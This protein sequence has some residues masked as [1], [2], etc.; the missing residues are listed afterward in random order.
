MQQISAAEIAGSRAGAEVG[1]AAAAVIEEGVKEEVEVEVEVEII[2][3]VEGKAMNA[4][5]LQEACVFVLL[6]VSGSCCQYIQEL[7][8]DPQKLLATFP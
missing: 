6:H 5:M 4:S 2:V 1:A 7:P 8:P 3:E